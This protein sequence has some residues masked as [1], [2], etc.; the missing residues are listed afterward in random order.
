MPALSNS[1]VYREN[2]F[3]YWD[4]VPNTISE[5]TSASVLFGGISGILATYPDYRENGIPCE[6]DAGIGDGNNTDQSIGILDR[7]S[8][9]QINVFVPDNRICEITG[10]C[11]QRARHHVLEDASPP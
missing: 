8:A 2:E 11:Y 1:I 5:N 4:I 7:E 9:R 3:P 6:I 10:S